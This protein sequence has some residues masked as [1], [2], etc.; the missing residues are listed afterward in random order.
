MRNSVPY[1]T[2][3]VETQVRVNAFVRGVY[4]WMAIGLGLDSNVRPQRE[5][6][7]ALRGLREARRVLPRAKR[8]GSVQGGAQ[9]LQ[10]GEGLGAVPARPAA[11]CGPDPPDR[12][13]QGGG[14]HA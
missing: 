1:A 11:A 3:S 13:V 9:A 5:A 4:N 2:P 12:R 7:G 8:N 10:A 14:E 6:P